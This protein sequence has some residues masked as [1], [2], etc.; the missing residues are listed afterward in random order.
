LE[1]RT[2]ALGLRR[3]EVFT[4]DARIL[5]Q[6]GRGK[7]LVRPPN[8]AYFRGG[9]EGETDSLAFLVVGENGEV[10]GLVL[11]GGRAYVLGA[12]REDASAE[13]AMVTRAV[14]EA[15]AKKPVDGW[16]CGNDALPRS[17][18]GG[19]DAL[20]A[21][22]EEQRT[23]VTA[24]ASAQYSMAVA[25]ETDFELYSRFNSVN[26]AA[27]YI[28]DLLGASS[29]IYYRDIGTTL[30]VNFISLWTS[31]GDPWSGSSSCE[32][33]VQFANYW[34]NPANGRTAIPR[35][36]AH[37][38]SG[39]ADKNGIAWV[40]TLC[41][42]PQALQI[43]C[44][45]TSYSTFSGGFGVTQGID[46]TFNPL[47]PTVVWDISGVSHELGHNFDS[48]HTHCY[49]NYPVPGSPPVDP[50]FGSEP[51]CY[52]GNASLP[53]GG[54]GSIMSYCHLLGSVSANIALSFGAPL[55]YGTLSERVPQRMRDFVASRP[56]AC[57]VVLD[58]P[59]ADFNGDG[60]S[61]V[62]VYRHGAWIEFPF[63]PGR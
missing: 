35:G 41:S 39:K 28:G 48:P 25:I 42:T 9:V 63:W 4:P 53:P 58:A 57:R 26:L 2:A 15:L 60:R 21:I 13:E 6:G 24:E 1:A 7:R 23:A 51:G 44:G 10:R 37:F 16:R 43:T 33:L 52:A 46:G 29:A 12:E 11:S 40:G 31:P 8:R 18:T 62:V 50:C 34:V 54:K 22:F 20:T 30:R 55:Q 19:S 14:E 27:A 5:V 47:R 45:T 3:F 49:N 38:L 59:P 36:T 32:T 56:A 61:E 17:A